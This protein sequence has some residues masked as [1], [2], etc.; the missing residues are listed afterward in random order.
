MTQMITVATTV[1]APV[2]KVWECFTQPE[3]ITKWNSAS[4]D[5]HTPRATNDL[6]PGGTFTCRMEARNGSIGFDFAGTYDEIV[7]HQRIAYTIDDGRK[8]VIMF[9]EENGATRVTETFEIEGE[10]SAEMQRAGW[11]AILDNFKTHVE[12][13]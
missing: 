7:L 4:P 11:Q 6:R 8:V 13:H 3:H 5:W 10:H 2:Q 1:T 12:S 9:T